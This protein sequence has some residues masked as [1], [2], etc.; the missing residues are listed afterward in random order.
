METPVIDN[1]KLSEVMEIIKDADLLMTEKDCESDK[2]AKMELE[3]LQNKLREITEN[4]NIKIRDFWHYDE[5]TNLETA[6]KGALMSPPEKEDITDEQIKEIV[7]NILK[8]DETEMGWWL[9][10]LKINTGLENLSDYIF[11]PNLIGLD[12][13]SSL[14][15]IADK[16]IVDRK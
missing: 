14:E 3:E 1:A 12:S 5:A 2:A 10:F 7:L 13:N 15:Q 16:I 9:Q 11:Y 8:H 6:A 4:H